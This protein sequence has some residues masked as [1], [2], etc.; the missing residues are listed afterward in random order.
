LATVAG[1]VFGPVLATV[2]TYWGVLRMNCS[3]FGGDS[4]LQKPAVVIT[5]LKKAK[6]R[7]AAI[8]RE[9]FRPKF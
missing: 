5:T 3:G 6:A 2:T 8:R 4:R 1:V 7:T 9:C